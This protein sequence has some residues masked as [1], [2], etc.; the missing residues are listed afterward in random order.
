MDGSDGRR[1]AVSA[2]LGRVGVGQDRRDP[3]AAGDERTARREWARDGG[4]EAVRRYYDEV[5]VYGDPGVH[6]LR[7]ATG[8]AQDVAART[9]HVGYLAADRIP[10]TE[11]DERPPNNGRDYVLIMLGGGQD[12]AA[13]ARAAAAATVPDGVDLV[14]LTGPQLPESDL[15]ALRR[16]AR[17]RPPVHVQRFSRH[18]AAWLENAVAAV[19]MGGANT[20]AEILEGDTPALVVPRVTPRAEQLVRARSLAACGALDVLH[21]ASLSPEALTDWIRTAIHSRVD[22]SGLRLDG[23]TTVVRRARALLATGRHDIPDVPTDARERVAVLSARGT[24]VART[25]PIP[26]HLPAAP[27]HTPTHMR[28]HDVAS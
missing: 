27:T 10:P 25:S 6:D 7:E 21:P 11:R 2:R 12:G 9:H 3:D 15:R 20:V 16:V 28:S 19:T 1:G 24:S 17:R 18:G 13:L 26:D 4:D 5:W 22:R 14:I 8:M 23:F